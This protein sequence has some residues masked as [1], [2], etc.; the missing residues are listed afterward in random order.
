MD[1][2]GSEE[3]GVGAVRDRV[4]TRMRASRPGPSGCLAVAVR[5]PRQGNASYVGIVNRLQAQPASAPI[6]SRSN[7]SS[8]RQRL[9]MSQNSHAVDSAS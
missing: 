3:R 4:T 1:G 9:T 6:R 7:I 5:R 8:W 2:L